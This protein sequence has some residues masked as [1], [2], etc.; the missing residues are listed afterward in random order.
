M[1]TGC[2]LGERGR[3]DQIRSVAIVDAPKVSRGV[4]P[5][6]EV[7]PLRRKSPPRAAPTVPAMANPISARDNQS[8]RRLL[9]VLIA[10]RSPAASPNPQ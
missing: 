8:A 5:S 2:S 10:A 9:S 6:V 1:S 3:Y 4:H 7:L